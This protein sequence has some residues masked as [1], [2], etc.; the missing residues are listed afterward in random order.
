MAATA[1]DTAAGNWS[2]VNGKSREEE[3]RVDKRAGEAGNCTE[4]EREIGRVQQSRQQVDDGD[5]AEGGE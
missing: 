3:E 1:L 4:E 2:W 5:K